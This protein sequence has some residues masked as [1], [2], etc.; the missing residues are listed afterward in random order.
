MLPPHCSHTDTGSPYEAV[1]VQA[2]LHELWGE[3]N[4]L[5]VLRQRPQTWLSIGRMDQNWCQCANGATQSAVSL[6]QYWTTVQYWLW[7]HPFIECSNNFTSIQCPQ[8]NLTFLT[9]KF[10]IWDASKIIRM[11][12][13]WRTSRPTPDPLKPRAPE[14]TWSTELAQRDF[15]PVGPHWSSR[16]TKNLSTTIDSCFWK[17]C[18]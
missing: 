9:S 6:R 11:C 8:D 4:G 7:N 15:R 14:E 2:F 10:A 12:S 18:L 13:D 17:I 5:Q 16:F 1:P 3:A